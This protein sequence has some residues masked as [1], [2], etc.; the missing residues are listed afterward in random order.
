MAK[1][2]GAKKKPFLVYMDPE[3]EFKLQLLVDRGL[4]AS[5]AHG[6]R[7]ALEQYLNEYEWS[8][9]ARA[10]TAARHRRASS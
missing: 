1:P 8:E 2:K 10:V 6:I 4:I 7:N 9:L 3:H 5:K